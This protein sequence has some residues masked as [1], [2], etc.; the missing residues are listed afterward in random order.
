M[1]AKLKTS[2]QIWKLATDLGLDPKDNPLGQIL[3][4]CFKRVRSFLTEFPC[5][6]LSE[7]LEVA[8]AKLDTIFVEIHSDDE[9]Q[10]VRHEYMEKGE[11]A[12]AA[13]EKELGPKVYAVTFKRISLRRGDRRFVSVIDCRGDKA[14]RAYFS[15]WH[16]LA[17]L[18]TL[19]PQM[20]LKFCRTHA[21]PDEKDPEERVMDVIAS[22][23]GFRPQ[24][25]S[26]EGAG[27]ISFQKINALRS[28]L[29]PEASFVASVIG[30]VK[31]WPTPCILVDAGLGYKKS[32]QRVLTQG[33]FNFVE[34][35]TARL[36]ALHVS[37]NDAARLAGVIVY[38]NMQVP[39]KSI[40]HSAFSNGLVDAEA[41]EDLKWWQ[42]SSG[43]VL[44]DRQVSVE[45]RKNGD[46]V[47]ALIIPLE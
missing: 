47:L 3:H 25:V 14:W 24:L 29:C 21:E 1:A 37:A 7:L 8:A 2:L 33:A 11:I 18:L 4:H 27:K 22:E 39:E 5:D 12:F 9:L 13:L 38:P 46:G 28:E 26:Y 19:T 45:V 36:R 30:F 43:E 6:T 10:N 32:V 23:I 16:E 42:T 34:M 35:P 44:R 41:V 17:H 40:I 31:A 15:K 20:R